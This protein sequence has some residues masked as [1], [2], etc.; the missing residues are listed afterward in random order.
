MDGTQTETMPNL[1]GVTTNAAGAANAPVGM[2]IVGRLFTVLNALLETLP[3]KAKDNRL[4]LTDI[5]LTAARYGSDIKAR[6]SKTAQITEILNVIRP[7][8][9][10]M[11]MPFAMGLTT[12]KKWASLGV[13]GNRP[14]GIVKVE[15]WDNLNKKGDLE[16]VAGSLA[17]FIKTGGASA[18]DDVDT[19]IGV[20]QYVRLKD[21]NRSAAKQMQWVTSSHN[22]GG[23]DG[24]PGSGKLGK[25]VLR[26]VCAKNLPF[27]NYGLESICHKPSGVPSA[28]PLSAWSGV[29]PEC[30]GETGFAK[31]DTQVNQNIKIKVP[32]FDPSAGGWQKFGRLYSVDLQGRTGASRVM[33]KNGVS[34][35]QPGRLERVLMTVSDGEISFPV[36]GW[37]FIAGLDRGIVDPTSSDEKLCRA[38]IDTIRHGRKHT[39][40]RTAEALTHMADLMKRY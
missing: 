10:L 37:A 29:C 30:G 31:R 8:T 11:I 1:V 39:E 40:G 21:T 33:N 36:I 34:M 32:V 4:S 3:F 17:A 15:M 25:Q 23:R 7:Q 19:L 14:A 12:F 20:N 18:V 27:F 2:V 6:A 28:L 9:D 24:R 13:F 22:A 5:R 26:L 16:T 38:I 35:R